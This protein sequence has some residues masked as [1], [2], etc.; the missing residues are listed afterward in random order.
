MQL[1]AQNKVD[2]NIRLYTTITHTRIKIKI[3]GI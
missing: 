1:I 3:R 2:R